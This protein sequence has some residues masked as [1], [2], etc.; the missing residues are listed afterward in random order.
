M[1]SGLLSICC[2]VLFCGMVWAQA[3]AQIG[4]TVRDE[5]GAII[6]GVEIKS[7]RVAIGHCQRVIIFLFQG[8]IVR[9]VGGI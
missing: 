4:G 7:R 3:T 8:W 1:R 9:L 2:L 6:P 5:S